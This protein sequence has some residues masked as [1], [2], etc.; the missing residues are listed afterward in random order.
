MTQLTEQS[1]QDDDGLVE[2]FKALSNPNRLAIYREILRQQKQD[3]GTPVA[4]GCLIVDFINKLEI[5]APTVSHHVK[6]LAKAGLIEVERQGKY[7][8][9]KPDNHLRSQLGHFFNLPE[10]QTF[11]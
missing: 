2:A 6:V 9:C 5:G 11:S 7:L 3:V 4:S 1:I 10:S 8:I